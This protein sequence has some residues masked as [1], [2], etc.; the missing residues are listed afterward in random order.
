LLYIYFY[1]HLYS[2]EW[3]QGDLPM[4]QPFRSAPVF[5]FIL[6]AAAACCVAWRAFCRK[7]RFISMIGMAAACVV[8]TL[9]MTMHPYLLSELQFSPQTNAYGSAFY[10]LSWALD[11]VVLIGLCL[12]ATAFV[13]T[14][15][16][17]EHW[18][19][20]LRLHMQM[21]THYCYFA[22]TVAIVVYA[23]LYLSPF[24]I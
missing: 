4:P 9:F 2:T 6:F 19:T 10:L 11:T 18:E 8:L 17:V 12:A 23:T 7:Q 20:F 22:A 15:R 1:L 13:R 16:E 3:P 21:A 14:W 24:L 5:G